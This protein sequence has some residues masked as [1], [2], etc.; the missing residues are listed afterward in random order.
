[1]TKAGK[2]VNKQVLHRFFFRGGAM[3]SRLVRSTADRIRALAG[4]LRYVLGQ[5]T[6]LSQCPSPP[7]CIN[8][9]R[10]F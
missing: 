10:Q 6:L 1:M 2:S 8:A 9:N 5:D 7:R 4:T 3:A